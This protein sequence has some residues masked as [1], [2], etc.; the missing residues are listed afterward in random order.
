VGDRNDEYVQKFVDAVAAAGLDVTVTAD[1]VRNATRRQDLGI[2]SLNIIMVVVS[3]LQ[4]G[5]GGGGV[6]KAE[7]VPRLDEVDGILSVLEEI[8]RTAPQAAPVS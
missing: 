2:T 1:D 7:W 4:T 6:P 5:P 8:D 3:Y